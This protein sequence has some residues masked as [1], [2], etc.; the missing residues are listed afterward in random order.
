MAAA[1]VSGILIVLAGGFVAALLVRISAKVFKLWRKGRL[2]RVTLRFFDG[3]LRSA[4]SLSQ[5]IS[6]G[7]SA[8]SDS[9]AFGDEGKP[10][11]PRAALSPGGAPCLPGGLARPAAAPALTDPLPALGRPGADAGE[12]RHRREST[13]DEV[14][15]DVRRRLVDVTKLMESV[16]EELLAEDGFVA[17]R[18]ASVRGDGTD[19]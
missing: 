13:V 1:Q 17:H 12:G 7:D 6:P 2:V 15:L 8:R 9:T 4:R 11:P 3:L 19:K 14:I 10:S 16:A 5:R 18:Y